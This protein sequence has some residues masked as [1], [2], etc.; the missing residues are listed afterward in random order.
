MCRRY[1]SLLAAAA[2]A[3]VLISGCGTRRDGGRV[4]EPVPVR[5]ITVEESA[6]VGARSY[7]G[8]V[9][10][11]KLAV[12]S[13][14]Y[15]GT[16]VR[17]TV[18]EGDFVRKGD[19][20]AVIESQ[21]VRSMRDM[22]QA[23]LRQAE[24][25]YERLSRVHGSG[26]VADVK[27][28]EIET[29]LSKA[30]ASAEAADKAM[31][32][33]TVKAPFDGVVGDVFAEQGVDLSVM[34]PLVRILDISSVKVEI[35]V[36]ENEFSSMD[37]GDRASVAVPALDG[38]TFGA[39]L[40]TKG[41]VASPVS[42]SYRFVLDP[43]ENVPGLMPGMVCKVVFDDASSGIVIPASVVR[44]DMDGR[45]VWTVR[46]GKVRKVH[47]AAGGFSGEG[48]VVEEGLSA[49]DKVIIEGGQKVSGGM[50]VREVEK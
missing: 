8:T 13:C 43:S 10:P 32:D 1:S 14:S 28:V 45:Y 44:T 26:S 39:V 31:E 40:R 34:E 41:L 42:H 48:I 6:G 19:T 23:T 47:I 9:A 4:Q 15:S 17:L 24:D 21:S 7:V 30:R 5:V 25:G 36:P 38:R 12:L 2:L 37:R 29:Q 18:S 33:C 3:A 49:G 46:D 20:V 50:S 22:A 16:L 27:M 35:S 11:A